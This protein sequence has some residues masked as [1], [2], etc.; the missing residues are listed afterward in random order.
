MQYLYDAADNRI[1]YDSAD[2]NTVVNLGSG[3]VMRSPDQRFT[4]TMQ[5]DGNLVLRGPTGTLWASNTAGQ[6]G[7]IMQFQTDGNLVLYRSGAPIWASGTD[8][9][10]CAMLNLQNDG[11][12]VIYAMGSMAVWATNTAGH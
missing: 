10:Q 1:Y 2:L 7:A 12:L 6:A 9:N 5:G 8:G 3:A 11:N 4:L